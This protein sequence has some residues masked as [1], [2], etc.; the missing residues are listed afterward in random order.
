MSGPQ[1]QFCLSSPRS[2]ILFLVSDLEKTKRCLEDQQEASVAA[3]KA[4]YLLELDF[5]W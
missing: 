3:L 2:K 4:H 5:L 1:L